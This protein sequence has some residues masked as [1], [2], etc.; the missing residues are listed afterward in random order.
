M[1]I[2]GGVYDGGESI[3]G[4]RKNM[5]CGPDVPGC[6]VH[7]GIWKNASAVKREEVRQVSHLAGEGA[8]TGLSR[9]VQ[10]V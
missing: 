8:G 4:R 10:N 7:L 3:I 2:G 9:A 5:C 1:C 6:G